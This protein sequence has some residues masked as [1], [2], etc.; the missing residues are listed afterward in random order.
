MLFH[1]WEIW[2]ISGWIIFAFILFAL[3][4]VAAL[5]YY[6]SMRGALI[7]YFKRFHDPGKGYPKEGAIMASGDVH[8]I[9]ERV[10]FKGEWRYMVQGG[11]PYKFVSPE[12]EY[13]EI[14]RDNF[15]KHGRGKEAL[16]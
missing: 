5:L 3:L 14:V 2:G 12:E 11:L 8:I 4:A 16:P 6:F 9:L 10:W 15:T 13:G 1:Q 7:N